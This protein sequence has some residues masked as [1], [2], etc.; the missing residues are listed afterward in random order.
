MNF[1]TD[2]LDS[3]GFTSISLFIVKVGHFIPFSKVLSAADI[4]SAFMNNI[5]SFHELP[6]EIIFNGGTQFT[7]NFF[8]QLFVLPITLP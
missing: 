7:S 4:A 2:L 3:N 5:F 8:V 6:S 1:I